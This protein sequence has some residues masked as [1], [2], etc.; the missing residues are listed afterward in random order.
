VLEGFD[1]DVKQRIT[2]AWQKWKELAGVVRE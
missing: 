1:E 2:A